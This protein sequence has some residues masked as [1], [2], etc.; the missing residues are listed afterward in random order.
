MSLLYVIQVLILIAVTPVPLSPCEHM[1]WG[2]LKGKALGTQWLNAPQ[3]RGALKQSCCFNPFRRNPIAC[4]QRALK[5]ERVMWRHLGNLLS[6][7]CRTLRLQC[8]PNCLRRAQAAYSSWWWCAVSPA[9]SCVLAFSLGP[10]EEW[11]SW[12]QHPC[13]L[14]FYQELTL[15]LSV[16]FSRGGCAPPGTA[17][18]KLDGWT[19]ECQK[20]IT[21]L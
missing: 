15:F 6:P 11:L 19:A 18:D 1:T 7:V 5:A 17:G 2:L 3:C 20:C 10:V 16:L 14:P 12:W 21:E 8:S 4:T 9:P 13:A